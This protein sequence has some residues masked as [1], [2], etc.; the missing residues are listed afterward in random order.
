MMAGLRVRLIDVSPRTLNVDP[1]VL[2]AAITPATRGLFLVHLLGNPCD[3][4]RM[5]AIADR[6]ELVVLED[7]CEALGAEW[8]GKCLGTFG[9]AASFSFF[10]S[11]HITTMEGGMVVLDDD[12]LAETLR[13]LRAH[14]WRRNVS[15][16][17]TPVPA[18]DCDPRYAFANWGFNV[19]PTELQ[20][21]FG[22]HQ[23]RK[24]PEFNRR[25]QQLAARVFQYLESTPFLGAPEVAEGATPSWMALPFMLTED[26]PFTRSAL[27]RYLEERGIET[28]P[29]VAGNVARQPVA[30]LFPDLRSV[31]LPG[32]DAVHNRG[33][34][35]GL[36]PMMTD[37]AVDRV[38]ETLDTFARAAV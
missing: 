24:L 34:Y 6:H 25:R 19:R 35:I 7:C 12:R 2:E 31:P 1:D 33:F 10:F 5:M 28:R 26:A 13:I 29:I 3:M 17:D 21:G 8:R 27:T 38:I 30:A 16:P 15:S 23:L 11:H 4:D 18:P 32:A 37:A 36:S 14:G 9:T 22:L 20:A